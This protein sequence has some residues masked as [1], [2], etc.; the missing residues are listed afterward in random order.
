MLTLAGTNDINDAIVLTDSAGILYKLRI[1]GY[2]SSTVVTAR[3][4]KVLPAALRNTATA[5][6]NFARNSISGL[7]WLE[8][9]TVSILADGAVHPQRV[10][11]SGTVNLEVAANI[12]T[13]GLPYQSDLQTLPLALQIDGFGQGRY[14][15]INK[16]WLRVFQSSGIFVGPDANNLVEAKQ[17]STEP[18]GSPPALKSDEI[19]VMLTPTWAASGQVYIRQNDPLPLTIVGLTLEVAIGG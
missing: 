1:V 8:G 15:N 17:R 5:V 13:I 7:S 3:V 9:K 12:V 19:L 6:W 18:Y 11:T 2:T 10:V 16:A 14:K 4:D